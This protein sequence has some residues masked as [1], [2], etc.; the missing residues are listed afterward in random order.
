MRWIRSRL[1]SAN[2]PL[3]FHAIAERYRHD[4]RILASDAAAAVGGRLIGPDVEFDGASFD[5]RSTRPGELFVP[6]VADRDG[7]EFIGE[8]RAAGAVAY[9]TSEPGRDDRD[10]T[11]IEV[12]DTS[13]ALM[14]LA[15]WARRRSSARVVG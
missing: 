5:S 2:V 7:H 6:I 8:A 10:G 15:R 9:L 1:T 13:A 11:A 4:V 3:P 14:T 12:A